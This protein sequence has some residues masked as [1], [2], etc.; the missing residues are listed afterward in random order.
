[1]DMMDHNEN[2]NDIVSDGPMVEDKT[3]LLRKI[4]VLG[5]I[6]Y[7]RLNL[8]E[9]TA[10]ELDKASRA[11]TPVGVAISLISQVAEIPLLVAGKLC[12]R[13]L[14][15]AS[16]FLGSFRIDTPATGATS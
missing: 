13:D 3:M 7:D 10:T 1:M 11:S 12:Q 15:E 14:Q 6:S 8:R 9:P 16:D 4:I 5:G 2:E